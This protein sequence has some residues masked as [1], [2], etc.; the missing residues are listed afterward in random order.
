MYNTKSQVAVVAVIVALIAAVSVVDQWNTGQN[1][2]RTPFLYSKPRIYPEFHPQIWVLQS[3][4]PSRTTPV[5]R[6]EHTRLDLIGH[7]K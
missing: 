2:Q 7:L 3:R 6:P 1:A 5:A 4:D